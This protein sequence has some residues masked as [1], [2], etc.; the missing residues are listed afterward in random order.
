MNPAV[1]HAAEWVALALLIGAL[2]CA[3]AAAMARSLFAAVILFAAFATLCAAAL[4]AVATPEIAIIAALFGL[5]VAPLLLLAALLLSA[6]VAK[7]RPHGRP[8]AMLAATVIAGGVLGWSLWGLAPTRA[9][10]N[11]DSGPG[12]AIWAAALMFAAAFTAVGLLGYGE[13][14]VLRRGGP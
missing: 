14:G 1:S 11:G 12:V 8:W 3:W 2:A 9:A 10:V 13:R 7:P 4:T 5:G 6:R